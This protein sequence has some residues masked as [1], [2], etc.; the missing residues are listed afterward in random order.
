MFATRVCCRFQLVDKLIIWAMDLEGRVPV[1]ME[2]NVYD[3]EMEYVKRFT[4]FGF[5]RA[6][7]V[8]ENV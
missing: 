8:L 7:H 3:F 1:Y 4:A 5:I 2:K 6:G